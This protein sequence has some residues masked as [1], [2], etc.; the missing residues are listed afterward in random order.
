MRRLSAAGL[1]AGL[2]ARCTGVPSTRRAERAGS[3]AAGRC[4]PGSC[5]DNRDTA[6]RRRARV[7]GHPERR[8]RFASVCPCRTTSSCGRTSTSSGDRRAGADERKRRCSTRR[9][10]AAP[11]RRSTSRSRRRCSRCT[12]AS[13]R[14]S[15]ICSSAPARRRFRAKR[16]ASWARRS[17]ATSTRVTWSD[18]CRV[19]LSVAAASHPVAIRRAAG[20]L[21]HRGL[22]PEVPGDPPAG[23]QR[24]R[25]HLHRIAEPA[26]PFC[27]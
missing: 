12:S 4:S 16:G 9:R 25:H 14:C 20:G 15:R 22:R 24:A 13:R 17:K 21:E 11:A 27:A 1:D 26:A 10:A 19:T 8:R 18:R 5:A 3:R 2:R 6:F 23:A 7:R